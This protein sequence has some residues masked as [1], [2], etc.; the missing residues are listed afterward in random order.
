MTRDK[1]MPATAVTNPEAAGAA[2]SLSEP[3]NPTVQA[4]SFAEKVPT[5]KPLQ[6]EAGQRIDDFELIREIGRG[7]F[8]VVFL[9]KQLSLGRYVALKIGP[10]RGHEAQTLASL[11]HDHI[12]QVFSEHIVHAH[13]IRLL[14]MQYVSGG[15]LFAVM[16][17]LTEEVVEKG[18]GRDYLEA[19]DRISTRGEEFRPKALQEREALAAGDFFQAVCWTAARLAAALDFAHGQGILHRDIKPANILVNDYGRPFLADFNLSTLP[20]STESMFGGSL[21]YMSPEHL[22]AFK[23][24]E[25]KDLA[26]VDA[27]SDIYSL[28]VV[29][30]ELLTGK[31]PFGDPF[32]VLSESGDFIEDAIEARQKPVAALGSVVA[33]IPASLDAIIRTCLAPRPE[34][35]YQNAAELQQAF[36]ACGRHLAS[37]KHLPPHAPGTGFIQKRPFLAMLLLSLIP[38]VV[39]TG[40]NIGYNYLHIV[41]HLTKEHQNAFWTMI[42]AYNNLAYPVLVGFTCWLLWKGSQEWQRIR[43][44]HLVSDEDVAQV[45]RRLSFLGTWSIL[46]T[47]AGWLPGGVVFAL[48]I[49]WAGGTLSLD[50][51]AHLV[52]S[53]TF[54]GLTAV[55]Y[56]YLGTQYVLL[57]VL[58]PGLY[59]T[60]P[61][62]DPG[63]EQTLERLPGRLALF[64]ILAGVIPLS[65][66]LLLLLARST[67]LSEDYAFKLLIASL[68]I[69]GMLGFVLSLK[70][71]QYLQRV[72]RA[73]SS[74]P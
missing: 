68:I 61:R 32:A 12:V 29:L 64:Q 28:G 3:A 14:C 2:S 9:A 10:N 44:G 69:L 18:T 57:R 19:V 8:A 45:R 66:A 7:G 62:P 55:V 67:E 39:G 51:M 53:F 74:H 33:T 15:T 35:R 72:V 47:C 16:N 37:M 43:S 63:L 13:S 6:F 34:E 70:I 36:E 49:H 59:V 40:I 65:G 48:A 58:L 24:K 71:C 52:L 30:Y 4:P 26:A 41:R 21:G 50:S 54:A 31:R 42:L 73:L 23:S 1:N 27:R 46:G 38:N 25:P 11:E 17:E 20:S 5:V 60:S 56:C 22:R